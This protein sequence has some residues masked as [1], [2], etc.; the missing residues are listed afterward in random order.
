MLLEPFK[1]RSA[2]VI[3]LPLVQRQA[4]RHVLKGEGIQRVLHAEDG[5]EAAA[6]LASELVDI[7]FTP[8]AGE[9]Y[10]FRDVF[11]MIHGRSPNRNAPVVILNE[12]L[13]RPEIVSAIKAG[14]AGV[15]P[16]PP[17]RKALRALLGRIAEAGGQAK[18]GRGEGAG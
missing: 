6:I 5:V 14:A 12:G 10:S 7:V 17:E 11:S 15:L 4:L 1:P 2:L 3:G 18:E 9:G 8:E 13:S 16:V